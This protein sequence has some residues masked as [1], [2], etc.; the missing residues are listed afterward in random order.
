[1]KLFLVF[2]RVFSTF[3]PAKNVHLI[4]EVNKM[5]IIASLKKMYPAEETEWRKG[6]RWQKKQKAA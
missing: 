3:V 5:D 2:S 6:Y 4:S 1:M